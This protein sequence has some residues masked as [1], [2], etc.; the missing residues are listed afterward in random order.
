[1]RAPEV[2]RVIPE[3]VSCASTWGTASTLPV[4]HGLCLFYRNR[5][6]LRTSYEIAKQLLTLA[7]SDQDSAYL[8]VAHQALGTTLFYAGEL[9]P[10]REHLAQGKALY[11]PQQ[12]RAH[13]IL[14]GQDPG[15]VCLSFASRTLWLLGYPDQAL[16]RSQEALTLARELSHP[17]SLAFALFFAAMLHQYRGEHR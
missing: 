13:A 6:E 11:D 1:M 7:Q 12:H 3:P 4:V 5:G 8:L 14:Y 17:F 16:Q 15:V 9:C 10:A 2:E